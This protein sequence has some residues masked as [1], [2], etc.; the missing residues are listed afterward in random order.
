M[1]KLTVAQIRFLNRMTIKENGGQFVPP[2]N[3]LHGE[4]LEY[5]TEM[6]E[7]ELF[8]EA[9]Y[10]EVSDKAALYMFSIISNHVFS[11]GN[12]RTGLTAALTFLYVNNCFLSELL[13]V[14]DGFKLSFS[15]DSYDDHLE[16]FTLAV[17]SAE[18]RLD[19]CRAWFAH[20]ITCA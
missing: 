19:D 9:L 18:L 7:A 4:H 13:T 10:P 14:P 20:N 1:K 8:G 17:A 6:V 2:H 5:L 12:K 16:A 3:Y 11:D 15:R